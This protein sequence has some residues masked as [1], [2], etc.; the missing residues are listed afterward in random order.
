VDVVRLRSPGGWEIEFPGHSVPLL[1]DF[2][3]DLS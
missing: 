1:V 2:L 3:R